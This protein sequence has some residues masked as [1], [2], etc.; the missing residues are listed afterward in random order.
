MDDIIVLAGGFSVSQFE[1][2]NLKQYGCKIIGVNDAFLHAPVDIVVS[3]D[4]RWLEYRWEKLKEA[5]LPTY[6]RYSAYKVNLNG[7]FFGGLRLFNCDHETDKFSENINDL[8]GRNSGYVAFNLAY[9]NRPKNIY[10]FGFDMQGGYWYKDY[11]WTKEKKQNRSAEWIDG[12]KIAE[13][14]CDLAGV[15]VFVVG[16]S[17]INN[18]PKITF[19]EFKKRCEK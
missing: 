9:I 10:L 4:R 16:D 2:E 18:F 1:P 7:E 11:P 13:K 8:N 12:F 15:N 17:L 19:K 6:A 5:R 14:Y 3:M